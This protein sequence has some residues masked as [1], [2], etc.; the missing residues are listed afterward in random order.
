MTTNRE[1]KDSTLKITLFF[2][3]RITISNYVSRFFSS[4]LLFLLGRIKKTL[5]EAEV[6]QWNLVMEMRP[7]IIIIIIS[8]YPINVS[9]TKKKEI[10]KYK[11]LIG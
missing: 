10:T 9:N 2:N 4:L 11:V 6:R 5:T 8:L 7:I 1:G 3:K